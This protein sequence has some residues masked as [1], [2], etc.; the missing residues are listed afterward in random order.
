MPLSAS[1]YPTVVL[2]GLGAQVACGALLDWVGGDGPHWVRPGLGAGYVASFLVVVI[3]GFKGLRLL[4]SGQV[5]LR[6]ERMG[7]RLVTGNAECVGFLPYNGILSLEIRRFPV[8]LWVAGSGFGLP[9]SI[10]LRDF[11]D[12]EDAHNLINEI[13]ARIGELPNGATQLEGLDRRNATGALVGTSWPKFSFAIVFVLASIAALQLGLDAMEGESLMTLGA[14]SGE[15]MLQGEFQRPWTAGLLHGSV[16][17]IAVN[18]LWFLLVGFLLEPLL[19]VARFAL[20][21]GLAS[22]AGCLVAAL[23]DP[24]QVGIGAS[25]GGMGAIGAW[26]GLHLWRRG[27]LPGSLRL[28][29]ANLA[30]FLLML[31]AGDFVAVNTGHIAHLGG[32]LA[33]VVLVPILLGRTPLHELH[34]RVPVALAAGAYLVGLTYLAALV[35]ILAAAS[36]L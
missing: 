31:V 23:A 36:N 12:P 14:N 1:L 9:W 34:Q 17:H 27:E 6:V 4:Q 24:G 10:R 18:S 7:L 35:S 33:G 8:P 5:T 13:R 20:L 25:A 15:R 26:M 11:A 29:G 19:G 21:I 22:F 30:A 32:F 3:A 2:L 16:L 28:T